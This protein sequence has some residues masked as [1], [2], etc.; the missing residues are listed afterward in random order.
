MLSPRSTTRPG[1]TRSPGTAATLF[2]I[3]GL[4][5]SSRQT[6]GD[7]GRS[8][9]TTCP[10]RTVRV[11]PTSNRSSWW[12]VGVMLVPRTVTTSSRRTAVAP[13]AASASVITGAQSLC[14][15][16][17]VSPPSAPLPRTVPPR[18][19]GSP[20]PGGRRA[21]RTPRQPPAAARG[22][23]VGRCA[24]RE[25]TTMSSALRSEPIRWEIRT[26]VRPRR[27]RMIEAW[28]SPSASA[29]S[30]AEGSSRII[31]SR[32]PRR[33]ARARARHPSSCRCRRSTSPAS[34]PRVA[35]RDAP[36]RVRVG[37]GE[38][39]FQ[40]GSAGVS[41]LVETGGMNGDESGGG[42][43]AG[44][45]PGGR[46]EPVPNAFRTPGPGGRGRSKRVRGVR[47][48]LYVPSWGWPPALRHVC[49]PPA[50][51]AE[52]FAAVQRRVARDSPS[53]G[54]PSLR[55]RQTGPVGYAEIAE[56]VRGSGYF[57]AAPGSPWRDC[58]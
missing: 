48:G 1:G 20:W 22:Y 52:P 14:P 7:R 19:A 13:Q 25:R 16:V 31:R 55:R 2:T 45:T 38:E 10:R 53:G 56:V 58:W 47:T 18:R 24:P 42:V 4:C 43:S 26:L 8:A 46:F 44:S 21:S 6:A 51:A 12:C 11:R 40:Q 28:I 34:A 30:R 33:R 57:S 41:G 36:E 37:G 49:E 29:S 3:S 9:T 17:T 35:A 50:Q 32:V 5:R 27:C 15:P 54:Q 39:P 23:H